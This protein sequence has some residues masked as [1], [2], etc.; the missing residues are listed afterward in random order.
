MRTLDEKQRA[1]LMDRL[2]RRIGKLDDESLI[3]LETMTRAV[4]NGGAIAAPASPKGNP[5]Q[6]SR[7]YFVT[8]LLAGGIL[9][10]SAGGVAALALDDENVKDWLRQEG[11]LPT[12]TTSEPTV[13]PG[14]SMTP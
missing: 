9:A 11:W 1:T 12:P 13:T 7:R 10:A 6:L 14:P 5:G 8:T 4:D 3:R 2:F